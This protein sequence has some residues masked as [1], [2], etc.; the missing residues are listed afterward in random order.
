MLLTSCLSLI[1]GKL[2]TSFTQFATYQGILSTQGN[3][4]D[5]AVL[6]AFNASKADLK[7]SAGNNASYLCY[8]GLG[9][10]SFSVIPVHSLI[11]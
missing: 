2:T 6:A 11:L 8:I 9:K 5:P 4:P 3:N 7:H 10:K 1:F